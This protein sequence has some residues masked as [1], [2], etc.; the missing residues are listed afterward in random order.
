MLFEKCYRAY[1]IIFVPVKRTK[2]S[3]SSIASIGYSKTSKTLEIEFHR[4]AVYQYYDVPQRVY[5]SL[6]D[7]PSIGQY[8]AYH[9][10]DSYEYNMMQR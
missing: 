1:C 6:I 4:G 7:A 8:Y 2:V 3:S 5:A 10:R 9:I